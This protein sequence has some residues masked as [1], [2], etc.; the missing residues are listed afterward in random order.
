LFGYDTG[1]ISGAILTLAPHFN[2]NAGTSAESFITSSLVLGAI[3]GSFF[4]GKVADRF[5]RKK[6]ILILA[7]I[8]FVGTLFTAISISYLT[9]IIARIILGFAVGGASSTVPVY[10]SEMSDSRKRGRIV[11]ID[12]FMIVLGQLLS[13]TFNAVIN[14]VT[15]GSTHTWRWMIVIGTIPAVFL[16]FGMLN[17]PDTPRWYAKNSMRHKAEVLL[18]QLRSANDIRAELL[19]IDKIIEK[20]ENTK[21]ASVKELI[22][23]PW[24]RRLFY[25][26]II[27]AITQQI[28]GVDTIMY[29]APTIL[30]ATGLKTA[31]A[32]SATIANGVISVI[33]AMFGIWQVQK[34]SRR[35]ML[36]TGQVGI[37]IS[38]F[39]IGLMFHFFSTHIYNAD[40]SLVLDSSGNP[41]VTFT[42]SKGSFLVLFF[43]L[44]FLIFQQAYV[45]PVTWLMMSEIFPIRFRA[46]AMGLCTAILWSAKFVIVFLFPILLSNIGGSKTFLAFGAINVIMCIIVFVNL[47][48]TKG[49]SLEKLENTFKKNA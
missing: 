8:F 41:A 48:E 14:S 34:K 20:E 6:N 31:T 16:Y 18:S 23:I 40:G 49:I 47:P 38:L 46:S 28:T 35:T 4:A 42:S 32:L 12:Q 27:L 26:G 45:S 44:T 5:G 17:K 24:I 9:L 25:I 29:Y 21:Q 10:L 33:A 11:S 36:I 3:A 39:L 19:G 1:V 13:Y 22:T 37:F 7:I 30:R 15:G 2:I 43:M